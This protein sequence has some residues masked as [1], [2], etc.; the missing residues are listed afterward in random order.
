[1]HVQTCSLEI[2]A[3][4]MVTGVFS[5]LLIKETNQR[6]LEEIS[7]EDQRGFVRGTVPLAQL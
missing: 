4:F 7:N 3:L 5:T 6:T 2:L 1:M